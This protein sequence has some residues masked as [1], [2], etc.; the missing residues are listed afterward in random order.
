M[1]ILLGHKVAVRVRLLSPGWRLVLTI[2][3]SNA[4][5]R[6]GSTYRPRRLALRGLHLEMVEILAIALIGIFQGL[7]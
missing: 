1:V 3:V 5:I 7:L 4:A 6:R 2:K